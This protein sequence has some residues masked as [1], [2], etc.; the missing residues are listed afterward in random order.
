MKSTVMLQLCNG[1]SR[2]YE[3]QFNTENFCIHAWKYHVIKCNLRINVTDARRL[4]GLTICNDLGLEN[5]TGPP[6]KLRLS[7]CMHQSQEAAIFLKAEDFSSG[8][9]L[10]LKNLLCAY[11]LFTACNTMTTRK[12]GQFSKDFHLKFIH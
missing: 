4:K 5:K 1:I 7:W 3:T 8:L 6:S 2:K 11:F 9:Q 10:I 12:L